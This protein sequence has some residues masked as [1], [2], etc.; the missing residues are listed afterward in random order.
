MT[1]FIKIL[2]WL[3]FL[4]I[5]LLCNWLVFYVVFYVLDM[6]TGRN[7]APD[8][9]ISYFNH[10]AASGLS[11][12]ALVYSGVYIV[13]SYEKRVAIGYAVTTLFL[14]ILILT[15]PIFSPEFFVSLTNRESYSFLDNLTFVAL[16]VGIFFMAW[17]IY[18]DKV[19]FEKNY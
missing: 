19:V 5:S 1:N 6:S 18:R 10:I 15:L 14:L 12:A 9:I 8:S 2:R 3:L 16:N 13:P 4:P 11:G 17:N 7:A